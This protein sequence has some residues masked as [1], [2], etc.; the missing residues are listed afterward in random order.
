[1]TTPNG[2]ATA[3][4]ETLAAEVHV[5]KVGSRQ[6]TMSVY[7]QLDSVLSHEIEPFGR[8][9]TKDD[10]WSRLEVVGRSLRPQDNGALVSASHMTREAI[11][12]YKRDAPAEERAALE[13]RAAEWAALPLIVLAG[14]R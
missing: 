1:M 5:L 3:T 10:I 14:L 8:V 4:V 13:Q 12:T 9:R 11:E 6:I 2:R 7:N